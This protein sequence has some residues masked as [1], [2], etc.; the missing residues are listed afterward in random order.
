MAQLPRCNENCIIQLMHFQ[1]PCFGVMEDIADV[2]HQALDS[3]DPPWGVQFIY[4]H[5]L[6]P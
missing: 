1:A 2:V 3:T 5:G 6:K 4:L